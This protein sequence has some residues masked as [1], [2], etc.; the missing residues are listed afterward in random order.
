MMKLS[1]LQDAFQTYLLKGEKAAIRPI[2]TDEKR[3]GA[4]RGLKVYYD[5]YRIRLCEILKL[6]FP[7]TY[8]MMGD[9][10]FE[11]AFATY[12]DQ[13]PSQHF[14]VRYFGQHFSEFLRNTAP[15]NDFP[16]LAEMAEFEWSVAFTIDASDGPVVNTEA[17]AQV[18]PEN[19]PNLCF[20]LHPAVTHRFFHY[21]TP[22]LW[23]LIENE[24]ELR[25]PVKQPNPVCWLFWRKDQRSF[26]RSCNS[27]QQT[28]LEGIISLQPFGELCENLLSLLPENEVAAFVAQNLYQMVQDGMI[29]NITIHSEA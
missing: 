15:Y 20:S 12:L 18:S 4:D 1:H 9:E 22:Q 11:P 27:A 21:D 28:M 10:H 19:W 17:F 2:I 16:V 3:F 14:S 5:A 6:D 7:K 8:A 24:E 26:F 23:Q 29:S 25:A 13:F